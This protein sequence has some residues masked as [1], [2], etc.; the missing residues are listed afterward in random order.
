MND[1]ESNP[2]PGKLHVTLR[3]TS[4]NVRGLKSH[5]KR[6]LLFKKIHSSFS[7][8]DFINIMFLQETHFTVKD[9]D[10]LD[11]MLRLQRVDSYGTNRQCGASIVY[12]LSDWDEV[13]ENFGGDGGRI[14][15]LAAGKIK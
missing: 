15:Y 7:K 5:L 12:K 9:S 8:K 6:K 11:M 4:C 14:S 1:I 10:G 13:V 3:V 2:G